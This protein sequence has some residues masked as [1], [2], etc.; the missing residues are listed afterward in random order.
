MISIA[1][2]KI[3]KSKVFITHPVWWQRGKFTR[4]EIPTQ[5]IGCQRSGKDLYIVKDRNLILERMN[6]LAMR[7]VTF[8]YSNFVS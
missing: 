4:T 8:I 6:T 5:N 7:Q 3:F 1:E 2:S